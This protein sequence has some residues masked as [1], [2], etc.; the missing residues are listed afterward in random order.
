MEELK[1][2]IYKVSVMEVYRKV[3]S[4]QANNEREAYQR[5]CDAWQNADGVPNA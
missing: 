1:M 2:K 3:V 5:A 4:I